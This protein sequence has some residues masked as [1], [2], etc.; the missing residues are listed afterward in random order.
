MPDEKEED[1]EEAS[2]GYRQ[3]NELPW[4]TDEARKSY[5]YVP[6]APF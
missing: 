6:D 1:V 5:D 3:N 4:L 2:D